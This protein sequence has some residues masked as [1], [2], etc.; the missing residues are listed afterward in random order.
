[1]QDEACTREKTNSEV[2]YMNAKKTLALLLL[3]A[4]FCLVVSAC[5]FDPFYHHGRG[6]RGGHDR[7]IS[8]TLQTP[9]LVR[10]AL[11]QTLSVG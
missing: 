4:L 5:C 8:S 9:D 11:D 6:G 7:R 10:P 1:M 3:T 2:R